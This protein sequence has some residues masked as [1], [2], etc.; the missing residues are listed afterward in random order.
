MHR[1]LWKTGRNYNHGTGHGVGQC[2]GV[3]EGP[4]R[5]IAGPSEFDR[6]VQGDILDSTLV[7]RLCKNADHVVH[8]A[9]ESHVD[10]SIAG[11]EAFV[12]SNIV[13]TFNLLEAARQLPANSVLMRGDRRS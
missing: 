8:F 5:L 3:H 6:I 12:R 9:A 13:G 11:P 4:A 1:V 10:R 7:K 2:L